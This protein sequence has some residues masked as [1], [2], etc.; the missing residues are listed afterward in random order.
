MDAE[1][2]SKEAGVWIAQQVQV[3]SVYLAYI[4]VFFTLMLVSAAAVPLALL[5]RKTKPGAAAPIGH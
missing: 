5:L 1:S 2:G 4:E 3:Q